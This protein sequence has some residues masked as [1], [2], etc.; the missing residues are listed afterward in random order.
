MNKMQKHLW[1]AAL[2]GLGVRLLFVLGFPLHQAGDTPIYEELARNWLHHGVYGLALFGQLTPVDV[3]M[4][5]YPAFL[6]AMDALLGPS[7]LAVMLAQAGLDLATCFL[8]VALAA[9]LAPEAL[10]RRAAIAAL[11]LAATCPFIANYAAVPLS[12]VL[13]TFLAAAALLVLVRSAPAVGSSPAAPEAG[14]VSAATCLLSGFLV[15]LGALVRPETPLLLAAVA[16]VLAARWRRP[17]DWPKLLRAGALMAAG[18]LVPLLPWAARN[19]HTLHRVQFLAPRYSQ[20]PGDFVPRGL[21][22]WTGTWLV[23]FR[24]VYL[25]PWKLEEQPIHIDD[26][27]ATAF[28]SAEERARVA[29]LLERYNDAMTISPGV[30]REFA[31]IARERTA[32][33]P[34]RTYLWVPLDRAATLWFTPRIELLPYSGHLWP[35]GQQWEE[36]PIDFSV[37]V[38]FDLLNIFYVGLAVVGAWRSRH[39]PGPALLVA[40][41]LVRTVFFMQVETPE[42]RYVL[43]CF[44]AVLA[45]G[46]LVWAKPQ[47]SAAI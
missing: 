26:L 29:A 8:T 38:G 44:P 6:A 25:V 43:E 41:I 11:W 10:R 37:T 32:R 46:A 39:C 40:F 13:A 18:L 17:A 3:R 4:P 28:D 7:H 14:S 42:A 15:G 23:R 35:L 2:L 21:Y 33:H 19:W 24:D 31:Q 47:A 9:R 22:A 16:L 30:D 20:L 45:L 34:L 12:E 36:D 27:P 1:C 5:G